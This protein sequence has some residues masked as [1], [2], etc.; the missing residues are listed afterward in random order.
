M[1]YPTVG[2]TSLLAY[3]WDTCTI[4]TWFIFILPSDVE[5][6]GSPVNIIICHDSEVKLNIHYAS[7][8]AMFNLL[9]S[10]MNY[11]FEK[12]LCN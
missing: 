4:T 5:C 7:L 11:V 1:L 2:N 6:V 8:S 9:H 12:H 3:N 10:S